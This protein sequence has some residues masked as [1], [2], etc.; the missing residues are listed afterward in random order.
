MLFVNGDRDPWFS[1]GLSP[2][3]VSYGFP[4]VESILIEKASHHFELLKP[5]PATDSASITHA[6]KRIFD[7]V[8]GWF[9][10]KE[11]VSNSHMSS[12]AAE[13][14]HVSL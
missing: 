4:G 13:S 14:A 5:D 9:N 6:R 1:G 11:L 10:G 8:S 12:S 2:E 7:I 3:D